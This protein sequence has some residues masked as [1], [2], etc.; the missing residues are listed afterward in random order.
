M[1][2]QDAGKGEEE[3]CTQFYL[4]NLKILRRERSYSLEGNIKMDRKEAE[5]VD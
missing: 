1:G 3:K 5:I 2:E 4:G